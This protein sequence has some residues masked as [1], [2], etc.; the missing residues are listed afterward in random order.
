M[1]HRNLSINQVMDFLELPMSEVKPLLIALNGNADKA[2]PLLT[3]FKLLCKKQRRV[4][5]KKYH[6][7]I[8]QDGGDRMK[9]INNIV[10][11]V[12]KSR[13]IIRQPEPIYQ[14]Y[15]Y[16][17]YYGGSTSTATNYYTYTGNY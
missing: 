5:A 13:I 4:L 6:P 17:Y 2:Q 10:D 15:S 11:S 8:C 16:S 12:L 3:K 7:D 1:S 9:S 14:Y